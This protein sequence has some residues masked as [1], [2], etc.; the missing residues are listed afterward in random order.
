MPCFDAL[1]YL[2]DARLQSQSMSAGKSY[3]KRL[4]VDYLEWLLYW[5]LQNVFVS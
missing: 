5:P 2:A 3:C 4:A 1:F